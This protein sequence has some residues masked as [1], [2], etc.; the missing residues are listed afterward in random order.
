MVAYMN[1]KIK[2]NIFIFVFVIFIAICFGGCTSVSQNK[3]EL[4][5]N[6][7]INLNQIFTD[8][9]TNS[10]LSDDEFVTLV[11]DDNNHQN[12]EVSWNELSGKPD[13]Y[14]L[15]LTLLG[16]NFNKR[17]YNDSTYSKLT[18]QEKELVKALF[19]YTDKYDELPYDFTATFTAFCVGPEFENMF[20]EGNDHPF[21]AALSKS[22][23]ISWRSDDTYYIDIKNE[24]EETMNIMDEY[25]VEESPLT[26]NFDENK[27]NIGNCTVS[28][29]KI[30]IVNKPFKSSPGYSTYSKF[31]RIYAT[32]KNNSPDETYVTV[33]KPGGVIIG[34]Y[35]GTDDDVIIVSNNNYKWKVNSDIKTSDGWTLNPYETMEICVSGVFTNTDRLKY[36]D[37]PKM[38]LYFC[39]EDEIL[40]IPVNY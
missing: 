32:V 36:S 20:I 22:F 10:L 6:E 3:N 8:E 12:A 27:C 26:L 30:E 23:D 40:T 24:P 7:T 38:D 35:Y 34:K 28:L 39:N 13:R 29:T 1:A 31:I 18:S 9:T 11:P 15:V 33:R 5:N 25:I 37:M 14:K 4:Y 19:E 2:N 16:E 17:S 21:Y